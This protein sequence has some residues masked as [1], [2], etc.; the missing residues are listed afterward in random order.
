M[1][2]IAIKGCLT[3]LLDMLL[4]YGKRKFIDLGQD[5]RFAAP[6]LCDSDS[7]QRKD[8]L[9]GTMSPIPSGWYHPDAIATVIQRADT[10]DF[11]IQSAG[12]RYLRSD[13]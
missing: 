8:W 7:S 4:L 2:F 5:K 1:S 10:V 3:N 11:T 13:R 6:D 9:M 12:H